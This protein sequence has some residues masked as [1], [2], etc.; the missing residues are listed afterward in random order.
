MSVCAFSPF[1]VLA[2]PADQFVRTVSEPHRSSYPNAAAFLASSSFDQLR[3]RDPLAICRSEKLVDP[4]AF[5]VFTPVVAPREFVE[6]AIKVLR[7]N[8]MVDTKHLPLE[9]RPCAFQPIDVAEVVADILAEA[10]VDG[11]MV[12]PPFQADVARE[13]IAH[14]VGAR[15]DVFND[16]A[17]Y[18][19]SRRLGQARI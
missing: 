10:V 1:S 18:T 14:D 9:M 13:L 7:A 12:E 8:P 5:L 16:F 19:R 6:V 2:L 4:I 3:V 15:F 17:L 11:V